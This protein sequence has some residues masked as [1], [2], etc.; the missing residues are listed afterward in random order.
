[1]S[2]TPSDATGLQRTSAHW[3]AWQR[4]RPAEQNLYADWG[5][6]PTVFRAV[7]RHTFGHADDNFFSFLKAQYPQCA[8]AH[9]LSLCCGDGAFEQQLLEQGVFGRITGLELS[10]ERMAHGRARLAQ[11]PAPS[12]AL[13]F[14]QQDVNSGAFGERCFDVVFAKAALHHIQ[15]LETALAGILRCLK[16]DGLLVTI[17]FFGPSRFQWTDAQLQACNDFWRER[18][19]PGLQ[20]EPDGS[21][22]PPIGRPSVDD[23]LAMDP[24]EAARSGELHAL[25]HRHFEVLEDRALG[26]TLLNLLLYGQRVNRFDA[27]DPL[28][29]AVLEEAVGLERELMAQ[30]RLGSDFRFMVARPRRWTR[31]LKSFGQ[32]ATGW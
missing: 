18:V 23:M 32:A 27:A 10:S 13:D 20:R 3:D 25:L 24:S 19:P 12:P 11:A 6:H 8:Q 15:D 29:S 4:S 26:G 1:M 21:P 28:H 17:D 9:A 2:A 31:W 7:M 30:G 5:D 16:P 22:T 14:L